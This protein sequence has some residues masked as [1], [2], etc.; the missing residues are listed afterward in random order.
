MPKTKLHNFH[1]PLCEE[2]YIELREEA[3]RTQKTATELARTAIKIWLKQQKRRCLYN[4]IADYAAEYAG[5]N[6]DIDEDLEN[7]SINYLISDGD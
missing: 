4:S 5:T 1:L 7:T 3:M 6:I 2:D